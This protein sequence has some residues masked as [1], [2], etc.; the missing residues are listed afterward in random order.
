[1]DSAHSYGDHLLKE[2]EVCS[3]DGNE[4]DDPRDRYEYKVMHFMVTY[5]I[6]HERISLE[7]IIACFEAGQQLHF[8]PCSQQVGVL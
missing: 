3:V 6:L 2:C 8:S 4:I 7:R 1:V 5:D